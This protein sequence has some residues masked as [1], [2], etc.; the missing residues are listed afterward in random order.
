MIKSEWFLYK[1]EAIKLIQKS[2]FISCK[3][4]GESK[5][6]EEYKK[7]NEKREIKNNERMTRN[8][9]RESYVDNF[10][11]KIL[12]E[13][14]TVVLNFWETSFLIVSDKFMKER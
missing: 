6:R 12:K 10:V 7:S 3:W 14:S 11:N 13:I 8:Y 5:E 2:K 9:P 1:K 4:K